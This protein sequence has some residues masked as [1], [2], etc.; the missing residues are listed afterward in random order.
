LISRTLTP[1][2]AGRILYPSRVIMLKNACLKFILLSCLTLSPEPCTA[3]K[4]FYLGH[5]GKI[6]PTPQ[7]VEYGG[8]IR[9]Q[10]SDEPVICVAVGNPAHELD[11]L[12][13]GLIS[14]AVYRCSGLEA[15]V[16]ASQSLDELKK[17]PV[18]I[19]LG[20]ASSNPLA[21]EMIRSG[22]LI[23]PDN[24]EGYMIKHSILNNS[25]VF[26]VSGS[27]PR[28]TYYAAQSF[29]Q[30][31]QSEGEH[32]NIMKADVKDYPSFRLRISGNDESIPGGDIPVEAVKWL[33]AFKLNGWAA[34][35]S[36]HWPGDWRRTPEDRLE[37]FKRA[38]ILSSKGLL[39][40]TAQLHPFGRADDYGL[41]ET[42]N[43][44]RESDAEL[45]TSLMLGFLSSG[46]KNI[47]L[48]ADDFNELTDFD[49]QIFGSKALAHSYL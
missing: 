3:A 40:I 30:L 47:L 31:I 11:L 4:D 26:L 49:K 23:L 42:I 13:A 25:D 8:Y 20:S 29:I 33:S 46:V 38:A 15:P 41:F 21:S 24:A 17:Y 10:K 22:K 5:T 37:A 1:A 6:I 43:I 2:R 45:L 44:H 14:R 27:S 35:Q 32:L 34:G 7:K 9:I 36:Y 16:T 19:V 39:D 18:I 28:G 12:S 48:R